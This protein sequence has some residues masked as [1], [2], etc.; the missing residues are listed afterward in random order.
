MKGRTPGDSAVSS[1][2]N[3]G[4]DG[5]LD[6]QH[7]V[8]EFVSLSLGME[9]EVHQEERDELDQHIHRWSRNGT[10][11]RPL[12]E[13]RSSPRTGSQAGFVDAGPVDQGAQ[14]DWPNL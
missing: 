1:Q 14:R 6:S 5:L 3:R 2:A 11:R 4:L 12:S 8:Q 13:N 10:A 9:I 7:A